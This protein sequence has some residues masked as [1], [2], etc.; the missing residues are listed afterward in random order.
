MRSV[1]IAARI[2]AFVFCS[3]MFFSGYFSVRSILCALSAI[4]NFP[5]QLGSVSFKKSSQVMGPNGY[6]NG[7]I[8]IVEMD[9]YVG[10][11]SVSAFAKGY[12]PLLNPKSDSI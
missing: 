2:P 9:S 5:N 3:S 4:L 7:V 11:R 12:V 6:S 8:A 1:R 10:M